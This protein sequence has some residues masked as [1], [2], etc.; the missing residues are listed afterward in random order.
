[1]KEIVFLNTTQSPLFDNHQIFG[2]YSKGG[3]EITPTLIDGGK[4]L[5]IRSEMV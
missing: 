5:L 2:L 1:M 4:S 3:A